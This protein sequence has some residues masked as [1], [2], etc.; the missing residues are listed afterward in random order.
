MACTEGGAGAAVGAGSSSN[1]DD[2]Y[3]RVM[4]APYDAA[5]AVP[6]A[7]AAKQAKAAAA[8]AANPYAGQ[9]LPPSPLVMLHCISQ[10]SSSSAVQRK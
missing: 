6:A 4:R 3:A 10:F 2:M 9:L 5:R 1:P 8:A 7:L